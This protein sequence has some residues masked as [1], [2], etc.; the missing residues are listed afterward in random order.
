[1]ATHAPLKK[2]KRSLAALRKKHEQRLLTM[3]DAELVKEI[4]ATYDWVLKVV[5]KRS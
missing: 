4:E 3:S 1:M 5:K 2:S